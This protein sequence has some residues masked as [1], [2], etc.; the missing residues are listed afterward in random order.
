MSIASIARATYV[1]RR[2]TSSKQGPS[3]GRLLSCLSASAALSSVC[4][5]NSAAR[6]SLLA[7]RLRAPLAAQAV[8]MTATA[9]AAKPAAAAKAAVHTPRVSLLTSR[10]CTHAYDACDA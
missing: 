3:T 7:P 2:T 5:L 8:R 10:P 1:G 9:A 4:P 6:T